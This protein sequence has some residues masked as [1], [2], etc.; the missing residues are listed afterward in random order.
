MYK[1]VNYGVSKLRWIGR[2][3]PLVAW[4]S[5]RR[6]QLE[7]WEVDQRLI[8]N[9]CIYD[10]ETSAVTRASEEL[11]QNMDAAFAAWYADMRKIVLGAPVNKDEW[12]ELIPGSDSCNEKSHWFNLKTG[13][14]YSKHPHLRHVE[15]NE[16]NQR[17]EASRQLQEQRG[18]LEENLRELKTLYRMTE[19]QLLGDRLRAKSAI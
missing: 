9:R 11:G 3:F 19:S 2:P 10:L 12:L 18:A 17:I 15:M 8:R 14:T 16:K 5:R 1:A 13:I 7:T 4:S 6:R